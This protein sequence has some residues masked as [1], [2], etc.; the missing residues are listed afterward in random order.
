[1]S[2]LF[3]VNNSLQKPWFD[4]NLQYVLDHKFFIS[5]YKKFGPPKYLKAIGSFFRI[6]RNSKTSRFEDILFKERKI[7]TLQEVDKANTNNQKR[8]IILEMRR[9][10]FKK[11]INRKFSRISKS[12][13][14]KDRFLFFVYTLMIFMK[15]P[16]KFKDKFF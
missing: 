15:A 4:E 12:S 11:E 7:I 8:K 2:E 10:E 6:H 9:L 3:W 16:Y 1:M 13:K 14:Y 5:L